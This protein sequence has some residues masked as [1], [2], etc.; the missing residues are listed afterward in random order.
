MSSRLCIQYKYQ[1]WLEQEERDILSQ[2]FI[3]IPCG[4]DKEEQLYTEIVKHYINDHEWLKLMT[5]VHHKN[6]TRLMHC[7]HVSYLC[8]LQAYRK[9]WDF[10]SAAIGGL[11]HDFCLFDK[12][13]YT[14]KHYRDIWCFYH[15]QQALQ[16]AERKYKLSDVTRDIIATHMFPMAFAFPKHRETWLIAYWDKYCA[17][18]EVMHKPQYN[19]IGGCV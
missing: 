10:E 7:M 15:P 13:D 17:V 5:F 11:L 9:Q 3:D 8:F 6:T 18:R 19:M 4:S 1:K 14:I 16:A 2:T 12:G